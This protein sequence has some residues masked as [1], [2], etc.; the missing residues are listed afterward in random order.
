MAK[1]PQPECD[2][3]ETRPK[4]LFCDL[5]EEHLQE[6]NHAKTCNE[7]HVNQI[8]F[9]EG[10]QPHGIFCVKQGKIKIYK[11]DSNG[12]QQIVRLAGPGDLVGFRSL[13]AKQPYTATA[14]T[15]EN[16]RICFV[17]KTTFL[18][19]IES[20]PV[21]A[22]S[23][24]ENLAK[25]LGNAENNIMKMVH[26]NVRERLA[27][28]FLNFQFKYGNKVG[29]NIELDIH[30]SREEMAQLIGTTQESVIRLM[31]EF[32]QDKIINVEGRKITIINLDALL[33]RANLTI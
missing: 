15:I 33:E 24:I 27:E 14:E 21:T 2:Q 13:L 29:K 25:E 6:L 26:R 22:L 19:L 7:Y 3:C 16:A 17:D 32:K 28:L 18:H 12:N 5:N 8:L 30:L 10:N 20:H 1:I 11:S 31:S 23:V 9:Y 4:S